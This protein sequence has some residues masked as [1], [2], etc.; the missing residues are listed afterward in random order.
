[1]SVERVVRKD[2]SV[3]WRVR[4]RQ[5]GRNRSKVLGRK[6]DRRGFRRRVHAPQ[7][8]GRSRATGRRQGATRGVRRGVVEA[9]R[10]AEPRPI[11]AEGLRV[12]LGRARS[13]AS[14]LDPAARADARPRQQ[15]PART[16][17]RRCGPDVGT[18]VPR[19]ASGRAAARVRVGAPRVESG[20]D[21]AQAGSAAS[22]ADRAAGS[23]ARR[24][25]PVRAPRL[26]SRP[27]CDARCRAR[28]RRAAAGRGAGAPVGARA[29]PDAAG[30]GRRLARRDREHQDRSDPHGAASSGRSRRTSPSGD[31][32]RDGRRPTRCSSRVTT[33]RHGPL[34]PTG[35]GAGESTCRRRRRRVSTGLVPTTCATRS[36][37]C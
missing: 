8:R 17:G 24:G 25:N 29:G 27:R 15:V 20:R 32:T 12:D 21:R 26:R 5:A 7:A 1:M 30:R 35:T 14:G 13:S 2:G 9:V 4:W 18:Q 31:C 16:R 19:A 3:V 10:G 28:V 33:A 22:S 11:D 37:R 34:P 23:R 6:R 36:C